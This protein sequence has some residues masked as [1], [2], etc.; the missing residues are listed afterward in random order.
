MEVIILVVPVVIYML[1]FI[2]AAMRGH[3]DT[4]AIFTVNL[5]F[6]WTVLGWIAALM[7]G[8]T[9]VRSGPRSLSA[10]E[11]W[12]GKDFYRPHRPPR[13]TRRIIDDA[14][15]LREETDDEFRTRLIAEIHHDLRPQQ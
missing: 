10:L 3:Q 11:K 14:Q 2:V 1:P 15:G 9:S 7:W 6:G 4:T 12:E 5:L 13:F 8:C